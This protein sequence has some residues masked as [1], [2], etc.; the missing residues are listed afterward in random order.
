MRQIWLF[1][2]WLCISDTDGVVDT[3]GNDPDDE[4]LFDI[5]NCG[6]DIGREHEGLNNRRDGLF[7]PHPPPPTWGLQSLDTKPP[8]AQKTGS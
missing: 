3:S 1:S 7:H 5:G 8:Y 4:K 6:E 2:G